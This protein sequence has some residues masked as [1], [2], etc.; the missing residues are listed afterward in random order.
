MK[1]HQYLSEERIRIRLESRQKEQVIAEL[2]EPLRE[3]PAME[4]FQ[5]FLADVLSREQESTTG[6]GGGV[7]IPHARTDSVKDFVAAVGLAPEGI[8]FQAV[9]GQPVK[10]IVL[11][12][13]P[14]HKV[15]GYL[16][17]LAHLSL[18]FKQRDFTRNLLEAPDPAAAIETFK[19]YEQ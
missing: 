18:L 8:D 14:S 12:G 13:V 15:N 19:R 11:M 6:I 7:A 9:D 17:L 16:K 3:H 1:L 5:K 2:A 10:L 4:D